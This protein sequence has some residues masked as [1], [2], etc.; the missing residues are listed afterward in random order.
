MAVCLL[1]IPPYLAEE[2]N[3]LSGELCASFAIS[4]SP[5]STIKLYNISRIIV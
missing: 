1:S 5:N 3:T 2:P 4:E